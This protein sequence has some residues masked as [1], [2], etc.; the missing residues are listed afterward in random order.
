MIN[1]ERENLVDE[2]AGDVW[3]SRIRS[4][5]IFRDR[6][7]LHAIATLSLSLCLPLPLSFYSRISTRSDCHLAM[8]SETGSPG[9]ELALDILCGIEAQI[10]CVNELLL[11]IHW[12]VK[13]DRLAHIRAPKYKRITLIDKIFV[14]TLIIVIFICSLI[15]I[16]FLSSYH[17]HTHTIHLYIFL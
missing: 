5:F 12:L 10:R 2:L 11:K 17:S 9:Q 13:I 3:H 15:G 16:I 1:N 6:W 14:F 4:S 8:G 7:P